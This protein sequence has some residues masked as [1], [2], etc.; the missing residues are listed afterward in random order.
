MPDYCFLFRSSITDL[1]K[2]HSAETLQANINWWIE[3]VSGLKAKGFVKDSGISFEHGGVTVQ[4]EN[5]VVK[6]GP[7]VEG[8]NISLGYLVVT[9]KDMAEAISLTQGCSIVVTGGTVEIR[10]ISNLGF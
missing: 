2:A 9:A 1:Q 5:L 7:F 6:E 8:G 10:P 3:W 4:G